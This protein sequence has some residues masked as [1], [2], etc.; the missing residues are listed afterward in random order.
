MPYGQASVAW[1]IICLW[2]KIS[3]GESGR[4]INHNFFSKGRQ[5]MI[6]F[7]FRLFLNAVAIYL[8]IRI[9]PYIKVSD[10]SWVTIVVIA[11]ILG[12]INTLISSPIL[13]FLIKRSSIWWLSILA[14]IG[15]FAFL[16]WLTGQIGNLFGYGYSAGIVPSFI[17]GLV[18]VIIHIIFGLWDDSHYKESHN[19]TFMSGGDLFDK[20]R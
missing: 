17:G 8:I 18:V 19:I 13:E 6:R 3:Y 5:S 4:L 10:I 14:T 11:L 1:R 15:I 12:L 2:D 16:F 9:V 20:L 7:I